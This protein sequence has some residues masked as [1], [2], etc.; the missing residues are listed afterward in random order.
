MTKCTELSMFTDAAIATRRV[1]PTVRPPGANKPPAVAEAA[2]ASYER[3]AGVLSQRHVWMFLLYICFTTLGVAV[4][5]FSLAA[6]LESEHA[7]EADKIGFAMSAMSVGCF[8]ASLPLGYLFDYLP[9]KRAMLFL[10][11]PA[12]S[13]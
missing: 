4:A 6:W 11:H 9:Y 3:H 8:V 1:R 2:V 7:F 12:Q 13:R 5:N 10:A